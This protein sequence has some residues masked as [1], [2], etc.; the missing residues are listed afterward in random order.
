MISDVRAL[1]VF[2]SFSAITFFATPDAAA[3]AAPLRHAAFLMLVDYYSR[4]RCRQRQRYVMLIIF[5][6][7]LFIAAADAADDATSFRRYRR[8]FFRFFIFQRFFTYAIRYLLF[9]AV[10]FSPTALLL[11]FR[12]LPDAIIERAARFSSDGAAITA[13][14][15]SLMPSYA[16][17]SYAYHLLDC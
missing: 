14:P 3:A 16:A 10:A 7:P 5:L 4:R 6:T 17:I 9:R 13:A 8:R 12:W 15:M 2:L 11:F 1:L